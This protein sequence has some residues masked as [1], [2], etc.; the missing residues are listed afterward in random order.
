MSSEDPSTLGVIPYLLSPDCKK[1]LEWIENAL[2]GQRRQLI[3]KDKSE[4]KVMHSSVCVNEGLLYLA[5]GTC[6]NEADEEK[7]GAVD[8]VDVQNLVLHL[9]VED[10]QATWKRAHTHGATTQ[11]DLKVQSWGSLYGQFR[12]PFGYL[13]S[14]SKGAANGVTAYLLAPSGKS[15]ESMIE[16]V[17]EVFNGQTKGT[18][19]WPDGKIMHCEISV[20][21][22]KLYMSDGPPGRVETTDPQNQSFILHV[23]VSQP[24]S[25]WKCA[26]DNG[27]TSV[28]DLKVQEWGDLYG[29]L[30][31]KFGFQWGHHERATGRDS[32]VWSDPNI[33]DF[34]LQQAYRLDQNG[35]LWQSKA[36]ISFSR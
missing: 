32:N 20:N 29:V 27:A 26:L 15:C 12:D 33:H 13:W 28:M 24:S 22:G 1:H 7:K 8:V 34:R 30:Q 21:G 14:I 5:D 4:T 11:M 36:N 19:H 10:P 2:G 17:N 16:W 23:E 3:Y 25:T 35:L 31:D 9:E 18:H 6:G